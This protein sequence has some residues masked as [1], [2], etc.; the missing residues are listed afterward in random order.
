MPNRKRNRKQLS[1]ILDE[2]ENASK[3]ESEDFLEFLKTEDPELLK[4]A[5]QDFELSDDSDN[6]E[7]LEN[8]P[9]LENEEN[10][11]ETIDAVFLGG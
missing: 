7:K 10:E 4:F 8:E 11:M 9:E 3:N 1:K 6:E 2:P 5:E